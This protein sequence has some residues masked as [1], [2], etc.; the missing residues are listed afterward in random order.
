[1]EK[2]SGLSPLVRVEKPLYKRIFG[3]DN[4]IRTRDLVLTKDVLCRLSYISI[5]LSA[6]FSV[7]V[8]LKTIIYCPTII[9]KTAVALSS[10]VITYCIGTPDAPPI[11]LCRIYGKQTP[12]KR[13]PSRPGM[14]F[15]S[16]RNSPAMWTLQASPVLLSPLCWVC[17]YSASYSTDSRDC[18]HAGG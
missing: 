5:F 6:V 3:A 16:Q 13:K 2:Q 7:G 10:L 4:A 17:G 18:R 8:S 1:M 12:P 14:V 15:T 9:V 11:F